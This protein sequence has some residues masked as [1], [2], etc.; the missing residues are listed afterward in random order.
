MTIARLFHTFAFCLVPF[1]LIAAA[2]STSPPPPRL[3]FRVVFA[4]HQHLASQLDEAGRDGY[5][6][7][8]VARNEGPPGT[9][10]VVVW[11]ARESGGAPRPSEYRVFT[12]AADLQAPLDRAGGDGFRLCGLVLSEAPPV[13]TVVAVLGRQS[14]SAEVWHYKTEALLNYKDS[15]ARLNAAG[16]DGFV[17]MAA[18]ALNNNRVAAMRN[19]MVVAEQGGAAAAVSREV[20]VNSDPGPSGLQRKLNE[21]GQQGFQVDLL[22]KEGND[23]VAMSSRASAGPPAPRAYAVSTNPLASMHF[24]SKLYLAD[25]PYLQDRLIVTDSSVS[26]SA[27]VVEDALP[28]LGAFPDRAALGTLAS[29]VARNQDFVP[30][31]ARVS[32]GP[33]GQWRLTTIVVKR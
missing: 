31:A 11:L 8:L 2:S 9:P 14:G 7:L 26:A 13:P 25:F 27:D 5:S 15:L 22:W 19:W 10:G 17:P 20:A 33:N 6:C 23:Y 1:A 18:E 24:L 30:A 32:R 28:V 12:G 21:R 29:H 16:R 3:E 4:T